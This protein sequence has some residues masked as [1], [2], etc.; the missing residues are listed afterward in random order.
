MDSILARKVTR[1]KSEQSYVRYSERGIELKAE[2]E[3]YEVHRELPGGEDG[4]AVDQSEGIELGVK[5][6]G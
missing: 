5:S 6:K 3:F 4:M 2:Q 1:H